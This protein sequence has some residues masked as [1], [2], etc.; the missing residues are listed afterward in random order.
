MTDFY[1]RPE[2]VP[3]SPVT[4]DYAT[5]LKCIDRINEL[6]DEEIRLLDQGSLHEL[7]R[8]NIRKTHLL[9]EFSR[10]SQH[11]SLVD[12]R[13]VHAHLAAC[14]LRAKRNFDALGTYLQAVEDINRMILEH[15]RR[16]ESDGTYSRSVT[17]R[18]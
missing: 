16:E 1:N 6:L 8:V 9:L 14:R 10:L 12:S 17:T 13:E 15:L 7:E 4:R 2:L 5:I 11:N 18:S 3:D